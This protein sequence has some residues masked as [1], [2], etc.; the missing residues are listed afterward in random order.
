MTNEQ[1]LNQLRASVARHLKF[2]AAEYLNRAAG[3]KKKFIVQELNAA[4]AIMDELA[5]ITA[6]AYDATL[7]AELVKACQGRRLLC[8]EV[9]KYAGMRR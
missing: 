4:W 5:I 1:I 2:A 6:G 9:L 8:Q 7:Q 3:G